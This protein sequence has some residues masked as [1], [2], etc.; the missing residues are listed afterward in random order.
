MEFICSFVWLGA[1]ILS[2]PSSSV[3]MIYAKFDF[4]VTV[5]VFVEE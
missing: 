3:F 2:V 1:C 4:V 5:N